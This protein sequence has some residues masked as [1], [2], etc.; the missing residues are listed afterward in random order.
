[1]GFFFF[2]SAMVILTGIHYSVIQTQN[3]LF[4]LRIVSAPKEE[5]LNY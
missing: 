3:L 4:T 2:P 1:M 5:E